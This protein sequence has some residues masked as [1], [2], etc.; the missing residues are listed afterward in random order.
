MSDCV[1]ILAP[2]KINL[3]LAV[4]PLDVTCGLHPVASWM[5][6]VNFC[7]QL[8]LQ[9]LP[10]GSFS[11]FATIWSEDAPRPTEI[12]WPLARDLAFRAHQAMEVHVG[13]PLPVQSLLSKKIPVGSGLGGG[14]SNAAAMLRGLDALFELSVAEESLISIAASLGSDVPFFLQGG[15][16]VVSGFGEHCVPTN[17]ERFPALVLVFPTTACPTGEIFDVFDEQEPRDFAPERIDAVLQGSDLDGDDLFNDLL[18]AAEAVEPELVHCREALKPLAERTVHLTGSGSTLFIPADNTMHAEAL[19][20][21][22]EDRLGLQARV[23]AAVGR[24]DAEMK[25]S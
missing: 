16:A 1:Q 10:E 25:C 6:T 19:S 2:A 12:D 17:C 23:V 9:K 3:A 24:P 7:D 15:D 14:S 22:I 18:L 13:R 4:G 11:R 20:T 21:A 5:R 8:E